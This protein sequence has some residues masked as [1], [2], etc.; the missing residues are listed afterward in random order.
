MTNMPLTVKLQK[1]IAKEMAAGKYRSAEEMIVKAIDALAERRSAIEG[2]A[3]GLA[4]V[5]AGKMRPWRKVKSELIKRKPRLAAK[6]S[7]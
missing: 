1:R 7:A 4:D 5:K 2:S 3:E 6:L